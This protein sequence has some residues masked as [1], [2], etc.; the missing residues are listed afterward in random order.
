MSA[1]YAGARTPRSCR[2]AIWALA[3]VRPSTEV[4]RGSS[5][6]RARLQIRMRAM[7]RAHLIDDY[8]SMIKGLGGFVNPRE[9]AFSRQ[10]RGLTT[11]DD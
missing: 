10:P 4:I 6:I 1:R 9:L 7:S 11:I 3:R 2:S 5:A 8:L